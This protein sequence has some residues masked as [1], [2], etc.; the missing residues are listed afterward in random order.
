MNTQQESAFR[1]SARKVWKRSAVPNRNCADVKDGKNS[2][3]SVLEYVSFFV[4]HV[5]ERHSRRNVQLNDLL[6]RKVI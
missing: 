3:I 2:E 6:F 1:N 5:Q 4:V